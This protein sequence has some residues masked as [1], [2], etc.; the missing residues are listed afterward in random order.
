MK[1]SELLLLCSLLFVLSCNKE[2]DTI[3]TSANQDE[4]V[5]AANPGNLKHALLTAPLIFRG[6]FSG[7]RIHDLVYRAYGFC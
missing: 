1:K 6:K 7:G 5:S 4:A 2:D 3:I